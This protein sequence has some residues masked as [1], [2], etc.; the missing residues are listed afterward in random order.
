MGDAVVVGPGTWEMIGLTA[1]LA[2]TLIGAGYLKPTPLQSALLPAIAS[3]RN[4]LCEAPAGTGR[5]MVIAASIAELVQDCEP[6]H[7]PV[8]LVVTSSDERCGSIAAAVE[9][10]GVFI[11]RSSEAGIRLGIV[12]ELGTSASQEALLSKP[13]DVVIGTPDRIASLIEAEALSTEA[14]EMLIVDQADDIAIGNSHDVLGSLLELLAKDRQRVVLAAALLSPLL[15]LTADRL[16]D[17]LRPELPIT[18]PVAGEKPDQHAFS[19]VDANPVAVARTIALLGAE[20]P[21]ILVAPDQLQTFRRFFATR[22]V[23][24]TVG[25]SIE[26]LGSGPFSHVI[27]ASLPTWTDDYAKLLTIATEAGAKSLVLLAA[28]THRHLLRSFGR[29]GGVQLNAAPLPNEAGVEAMRTDRIEQLVRDQLTRVSAQPTPRF[30]QS[31]HQLAAEFDVADVAAAAMDLAHRALQREVKPGADLPLLLKSPAPAPGASD[32]RV[33]PSPEANDPNRRR[34]AERRQ[35][36]VEP[37]MI[38]LFVAAGYNYGVRPGDIVGAFAG[39]SGLSG[40]E[41]G[42]IDIR[43][44]FTLVEVPED[45]ADDVISAMADGTIKGRQIEVRRERY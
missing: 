14:V 19:V 9:T 11:R 5:T 23:T 28:P 33:Q 29:V 31:V 35:R 39:E 34:G 13:L 42:N 40:K 24:A 10:C 6:G 36:E 37:G 3:E 21:A 38:R 18:D 17:P 32:R 44:T 27:V 1:D 43:E 20:H 12:S 41:I 7:D 22:A 16:I 30:L 45:S 25:A 26:E 15:D 4:V 8:A 2:S